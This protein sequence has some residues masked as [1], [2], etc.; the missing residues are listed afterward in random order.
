MPINLTVSA[1]T[2]GSATALPTMTNTLGNV[3]N[4]LAGAAYLNDTTN[5][6]RY[7]GG[8]T[9]L[10]DFWFAKTINGEIE[11]WA[12]LMAPVGCKSNDSYPVFFKGGTYAASN[13]TIPFA[14]GALYSTASYDAG[15]FYNGAAGYAILA[16]PYPFA[17]LD[18]SDVSLFDFPA[19]VIVSNALIPTSLHARGRLPDIGLCSGLVTGSGSGSR[20]CPIGTTIKDGL[21]N[22][23]YVTLNQMIVPYNALLS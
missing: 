18:A 4:V 1:P 3:G 13:T 14:S 2:G 9:S 19:W 22:V 21:G 23:K 12:I 11:H 16:P 7:Y 6:R 8:V 15:K 5:A 10:G 20:P 17:Q